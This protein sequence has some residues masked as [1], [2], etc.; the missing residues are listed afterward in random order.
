MGGGR[1]GRSRSAD[2]TEKFW[3]PRNAR[4]EPLYYLI[5]GR[6]LHGHQEDVSVARAEQIILASV[7]RVY[8]VIKICEAPI[9]HARAQMLTLWR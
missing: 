8:F 3:A 2:A 9:S 6:E 7:S 1:S 4:S 5:R